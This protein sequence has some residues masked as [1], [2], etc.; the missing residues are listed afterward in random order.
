MNSEDDVIRFTESLS[1][2]VAEHIGLWV[3]YGDDQ[4]LTI[5]RWR[6]DV[7]ELCGFSLA[8]I[9][10]KG[11]EF[12]SMRMEYRVDLFPTDPDRIRRWAREIITILA[13]GDEALK[14]EEKEKP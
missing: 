6:V 10:A 9:Y 14:K 12:P 11:A 2:S 8:Y 7:V 5:G 4:R 13:A 3:K 1:E